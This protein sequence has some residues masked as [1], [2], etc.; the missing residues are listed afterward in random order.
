MTAPLESGHRP[1]IEGLRALAILLVIAAHVGVPQL[2]GGFIGVDVFFVLSGYLIT[3]Q[4]TSEQ[5]RTGRIRIAAFYA[6][7]FR[8]L[9][10]ALLVVLLA[11]CVFANLLLAPGDLPSQAMAAATAVVWLSNLHFAFSGLDY[12]GP[13][14]SQNLFLHT[15]SL[16]VEEQFYL[17]WP[18][19]LLLAARMPARW[20]PA[21]WRVRVLLLLVCAASLTAC[22]WLA[23]KQGLLAFYLMPLRAWQFALG[24]LVSLQITAAHWPGQ[25]LASALP[26]LGLAAIL[27]AAVWLHDGR[28]YPDAWSLAPTLGTALLLAAGTAAPHNGVSRGLGAAPL[29]YLGRISYTWYLW[30]WPVLLLGVQVLPASTLPHRLGLAVLSLLLAAATTALIEQPLRRQEW[31]LSGPGRTVIA[32]VMVMVAAHFAAWEFRN[33]V[34]AALQ[35]PENLKHLAVRGDIAEI[36]RI[37]CD[38]WYHSADVRPCVFGLPSASHKAVI[39]GDS[40]ALQW[41]PALAAVF[42]RPDWQ[43]VAITKS[44]CPMVDSP[45]HYARIGREYTECAI[46]REEALRQ[47]VALKPDM[48]ILGSSYTYALDDQA[49][50]EGSARILTA[51]SPATAAVHVLRPTPVLPFDGPSCLAPRSALYGW[52]AGQ[53]RCAA[54]PDDARYQQVHGWI[55]AAAARFGNVHVLDLNG[56]VCPGE[57]CRAELNGLTTFRDTQHLSAGFA[58][59]LAPVIAEQLGMARAGLGLDR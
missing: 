14:A 36:Y 21:R 6:R 46:W 35:Q 45:I 25:R 52:L 20:V 37:G 16:G 47:I 8:R 2:A 40:I 34:L 31:L 22:L 13:A 15:W 32:A 33:R 23:H 24:G 5:A 48:V 41:F 10:P 51:L 18:P 26:G 59:S 57:I 50:V 11:S 44:A 42:D 12:F 39:I 56:A 17:L 49:W 55:E 7:R 1:D 9:M 54:R 29:Q 43:L 30:H 38:D 3:G 53:E 58:A 28:P 4:L 19:L 27:C